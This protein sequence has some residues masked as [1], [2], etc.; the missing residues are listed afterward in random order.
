MVQQPCIISNIINSFAGQQLQS[1]FILQLAYQ[2]VWNMFAWSLWQKSFFTNR[3]FVPCSFLRLNLSFITI[4]AFSHCL[5]NCSCSS[6]AIFS[7]IRSSF[8]SVSVSSV[9]ISAFRLSVIC[10]SVSSIVYSFSTFGQPIKK[11]IR[12][13][14]AVPKDFF[15]SHSCAAYRSC[16]FYSNELLSG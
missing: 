11:R 3:R 7:Y 15:M 6:H 5:G 8:P 1:I 13:W 10:E 16:S 14:N 4:C 12:K 2:C 9:N